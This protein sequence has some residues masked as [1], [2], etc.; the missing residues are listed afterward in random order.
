MIANSRMVASQGSI[1][2]GVCTPSMNQNIE[3]SY[4]RRSSL[5]TDEYAYRSCQP[6]A[7][8]GVGISNGPGNRSAMVVLPD[9]GPAAT[10][11]DG[12]LL[13]CGAA[14]RLRGPPPAGRGGCG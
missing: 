10:A 14:S 9:A 6:S 1:T 7:P 4:W 11:A 12:V 2:S 5:K 3:S 13:L 8:S